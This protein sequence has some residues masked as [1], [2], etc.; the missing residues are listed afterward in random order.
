[1]GLNLCLEKNFAKA[2]R[3]LYESFINYK[4]ERKKLLMLKY[5]GLAT[6]LGRT[7]IDLINHNPEARMYHFILYNS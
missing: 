7:E 2:S 4:D 5:A 3:I 1:M 6:I